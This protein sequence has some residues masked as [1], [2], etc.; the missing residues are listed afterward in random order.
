MQLHSLVFACAWLALLRRVAHSTLAN[1]Y[2]P[3]LL[4]YLQHRNSL[5]S[6]AKYAGTAAARLAAV[7]QHWHV[8][9][10]GKAIIDAL[11]N[12]EANVNVQKAALNSYSS[13]PHLD[14]CTIDGRQSRL[15]CRHNAGTT[16]HPRDVTSGRHCEY[17]Q[18]W[19]ACNK[20]YFRAYLPAAA[21]AKYS[22]RAQD[23]IERC[24]DVFAVAAGFGVNRRVFYRY[25]WCLCRMCLADPLLMSPGCLRRADV[26][27]LRSKQYV[28]VR[29]CLVSVVGG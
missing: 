12:Q 14:S 6:S 9:H 4:Y 15:V 5:L 3:D 7:V 28:S 24:S 26:G 21:I 22:M 2:L 20:G 29:M 11:G 10:H 16:P 23:G 18:A 25:D 27:G 8:A 1:H 19:S 17:T 13:A